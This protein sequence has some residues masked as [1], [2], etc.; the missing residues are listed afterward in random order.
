MDVAEP[1]DAVGALAA[2]AGADAESI[3]AARP[4]AEALQRKFVLVL[5]VF[6]S[7]LGQLAEQVDGV[8]QRAE[9]PAE[10][11][12]ESFLG[13]AAWIGALLHHHSSP[14]IELVSLCRRRSEGPPLDDATAMPP[15]R[16]EQGWSQGRDSRAAL[17]QLGRGRPRALLPDHELALEARALVFEPAKRVAICWRS[18]GFAPLASVRSVAMPCRPPAALRRLF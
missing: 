15:P 7:G 6:G 17:P 13:T 11:D 12:L 16:F 9:Q 3:D 5:Q 14:G 18:H 10:L 4:I 8:P 1:L 2:A